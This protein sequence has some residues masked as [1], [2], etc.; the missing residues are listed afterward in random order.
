M[1]AP[2]T[3]E[4]KP[5]EAAELR[6]RSGQPHQRIGPAFRCDDFR[7]VARDDQASMAPF[8]H[9]PVRPDRHLDEVARL[10][11]MSPETGVMQS[12]R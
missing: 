3:P 4:I 8:E 7:D 6:R 10:R 1:N 12:L 5:A 11:T 2:V 9:E